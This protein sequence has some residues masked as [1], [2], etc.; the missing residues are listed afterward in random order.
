[1]V[2]D[3]SMLDE[4]E[5]V[6]VRAARR[7]HLVLP[8]GGVPADLSSLRAI[9]VRLGKADAAFDFLWSSD[10]PAC[11]DSAGVAGA[12]AARLYGDVLAEP[13][14]HGLD[15]SSG[16][17]FDFRPPRDWWDGDWSVSRRCTPATVHTVRARLLFHGAVVLG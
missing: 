13:V 16:R 17:D 4:T 5:C 7:L 12:I 8:G 10:R 15:V 11:C 3:L 1:M 6:L 2:P 14:L 9:V